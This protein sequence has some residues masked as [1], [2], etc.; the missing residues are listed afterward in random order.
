MRQAIALH[1]SLSEERSSSICRYISIF[2]P[3]ENFQ[4]CVFVDCSHNVVPSSTRLFRQWPTCC[5]GT[6][7]FQWNKCPLHQ[8]SNESS[9]GYNHAPTLA[10]LAPSS[11]RFWRHCG[12]L[13]RRENALF[14]IFGIFPPWR[15]VAKNSLEDGGRD[16][17]YWIRVLW[18]LQQW[19][20]AHTMVSKH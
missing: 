10:W 6:T 9:Q 18:Q 8:T 15:I 3:K 20:F 12:L 7:A 11:C 13:Q 14:G 4:K 1:A 2:F 16:T 19:L 17:S 5:S